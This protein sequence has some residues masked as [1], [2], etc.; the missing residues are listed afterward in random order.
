[1]PSAR[2]GIISYRVSMR[3]AVVSD[4]HGN[5]PAL[6]TVLSRIES[7]GAD[8]LLCCGDLVGYGANPGECID[9]IQSK[10]TRCIRGNHEVA[11]L[12]PRHADAFNEYARE[13]IYWTMG[14]LSKSQMD[15][16]KSLSDG[17]RWEDIILA[18]GSL[19][20]PDEY[21]FSEHQADANLNVMP[22]RIGCIGHTHYPEAYAMDPDGMVISNPDDV[23]GEGIFE[24]L[25]GYR[26]LINVG[27]VGQPRDGYNNASFCLLDM[28][29]ASAE[30]IRVEYDIGRAVEAIK[31][32]GLP[33]ILGQR[34]YQ[35]R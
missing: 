33:E 1:M 23:F 28:N 30:L 17:A 7:E 4:I 32:S 19:L 12:D 24:L 2:L 29:G 13:A 25:D 9:I 34:L 14:E 10:A 11:L 26:Y 20:D 3:V 6:E 16:I 27:S 21:V 22:C 8:A 31:E 15:Y 18:H 35:G 5:L